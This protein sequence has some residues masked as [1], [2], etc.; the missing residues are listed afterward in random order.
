MVENFEG[1]SDQLQNFSI[2][3][4]SSSGIGH[5]ESSIYPDGFDESD[6]EKDAKTFLRRQN[7]FS[8]ISTTTYLIHAKEEDPVVN[9]KPVTQAVLQNPTTWQQQQKSLHYSEPAEEIDEEIQSVAIDDSKLSSI[10]MKLEEK[11]RQIEQEKRRVEA[12][13]SKQLQKVGKAAFL[14][15][16]KKVSHSIFKNSAEF[17]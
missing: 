9:G 5:T 1:G 14:K 4:G 10:R 6:S 3:Y 15:T 2:G 13:M 17:Y 16:V 11:R 8:N 7:S 12:A